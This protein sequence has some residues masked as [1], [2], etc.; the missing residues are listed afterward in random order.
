MKHVGNKNADVNVSYD[1]K[2]EDREG[3]STFVLKLNWLAGVSVF[4]NV[5]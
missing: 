2:M 5:T 1:D 4:K 3:S